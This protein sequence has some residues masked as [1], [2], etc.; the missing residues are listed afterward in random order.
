MPTFEETEVA[1]IL[2]LIYNAG[3]WESLDPQIQTK[4]EALLQQMMDEGIQLEGP[5]SQSPR[6]TL[7]EYISLIGNALDLSELQSEFWMIVIKVCYLMMA[8]EKDPLF[9][10]KLKESQNM[11]GYLS[12]VFGD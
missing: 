10:Q 4:S 6:L 2:L 1:K 9:A 12:E 5:K 3:F 7:N 11:R 8:A